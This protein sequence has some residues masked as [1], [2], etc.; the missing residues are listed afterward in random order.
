MINGKAGEW[1]VFREAIDNPQIEIPADFSP[2]WIIDVNWK[3]NPPEDILSL[4]AIAYNQK[5]Y[6]RSHH[7]AIE[8]IH[9]PQHILKNAEIGLHAMV[10]GFNQIPGHTT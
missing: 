6:I 3:G 7:A 10:S 2:E 9:D 8:Q 5:I 4:A 1:R